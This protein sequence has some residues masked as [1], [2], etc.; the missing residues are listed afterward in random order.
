MGIEDLRRALAEA[1]AA[2]RE[3]ERVVQQRSSPPPPTA[4][5]RQQGGSHTRFLSPVDDERQSIYSSPRQVRRAR[6]RGTSVLVPDWAGWAVPAPS[7][8][9]LPNARAVHG[10]P[11]HSAAPAHEHPPACACLHLRRCRRRVGVGGRAPPGHR[12]QST[13]RARRGRRRMLRTRR[14]RRTRR[15]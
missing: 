6:T 11:P 7:H 10:T 12:N 2:R 8:P 3:G 15:R 9:P 1:K 5:S 14:T 13:G 4:G